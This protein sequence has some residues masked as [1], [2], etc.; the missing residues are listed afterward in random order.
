MPELADLEAA[1][2]RSG[3]AIVAFSGGVDSSLVAAV[4][5]RMLGDRA[6][7][8]TA[9]SPALASGELAGARAVAAAIGVAHEV[10]RTDELAR[11]GYRRNGPDRCY[12]CK[13]ELYEQLGAL[14]DARGFA[15]LYSGANL[16]DLGDW[17]PGLRAASEHGVRHPLVEAGFG[18]ADVRSLAHELAIPSA[19]KPAMPCLASR[20]PHG[21]EVDPEV[22][23]QVDRAERALRALGFRELRVRHLGSTGRVELGAEDLARALEADRAA[24]E[25]AVLAAGYGHVEIDPEPFRSGTLTRGLRMPLPIL[26][27]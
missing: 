8:V 22:L 1:V 5:A 27:V 9:V 6:L 2:G 14:A 19:D 12:H 17:R 7:A 15:T 13:T 20:L 11:D 16:D 10:I 18:K 3:S 4:A 26:G 25:Q 23:A 21:T 24:V